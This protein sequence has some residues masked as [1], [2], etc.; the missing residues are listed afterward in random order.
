MNT[1]FLKCVKVAD[2]KAATGHAATKEVL[3][4][5]IPDENI[6][7]LSSDWV[8]APSSERTS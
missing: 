5:N 3:A 1:T 2:G 4:Y 7:G 6:A 8:P